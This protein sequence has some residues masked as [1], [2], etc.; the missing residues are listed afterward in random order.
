MAAWEHH[1]REQD[2][3]DTLGEHSRFRHFRCGLREAG[4]NKFECGLQS[5][6]ASFPDFRI[7]AA[8]IGWGCS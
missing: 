1:V 7:L 3:G 2:R 4:L 8:T 5:T 6:F